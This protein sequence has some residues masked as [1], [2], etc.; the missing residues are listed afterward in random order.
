MRIIA[1]SVW[2]DGAHAPLSNFQTGMPSILA[3]SAR[4]AEIPE[5]GNTM[6]PIGITAS[7]WS[8]RRNGAALAWRGP[9]GVK[10]VW[11]ALRAVAPAAAVRA[12]ALRR[13]PRGRTHPG[14]VAG[15]AVG[16]PH[17]ARGAVQC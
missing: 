16:P 5:P 12:A 17:I 11:G 8:L 15:T 13:A 9:A 7:I 2:N 3:L 1:N 10:A 4:F 6:T 14:C